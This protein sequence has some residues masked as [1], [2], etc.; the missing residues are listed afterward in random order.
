MFNRMQKNN[1][2]QQLVRV[3]EYEF[4]ELFREKYCKVIESNLTKKRRNFNLFFF[5]K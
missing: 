2:I 4:I 5:S 3:T 1:L